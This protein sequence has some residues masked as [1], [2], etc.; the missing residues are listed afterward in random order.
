MKF[1]NFDFI[2]TFFLLQHKKIYTLQLIIA[3]NFS[4]LRY[5]ICFQE[6]SLPSLR[7]ISIQQIWVVRLTK[8]AGKCFFFQSPFEANEMFCVPNKFVLF[9][10]HKQP[11]KCVGQNSYLDL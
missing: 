1:M 8:F 6:F 5:D 3:L 9:G 4:L 11:L 2:F 7:R 10:N